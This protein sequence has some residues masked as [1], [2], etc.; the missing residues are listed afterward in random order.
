MKLNVTPRYQT[1]HPLVPDFSSFEF[2]RENS[3]EDPML[4]SDGET[5]VH[6]PQKR[7]MSKPEV[8][9]KRRRGNELQDSFLQ[10]VVQ[11]ARRN[12]VALKRPRDRQPPQRGDTQPVET[13]CD[14]G[15]SSLPQSPVVSDSTTSDDAAIP[16]RESLYQ[17]DILRNYHEFT[18][19]RRMKDA[20]FVIS[21][22]SDGEQ[23][24]FEGIFM[25][26]SDGWSPSSDVR[27][28]DMDSTMSDEQ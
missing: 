17:E 21:P 23:R 5:V 1:P 7:K 15:Y 13:Q 18:D 6:S 16:K 20:G 4:A 24:V 12:R 10:E 3:P 19:R 25:G 11:Y 27:S 9:A 26:E 28:Q 2:L 8:A 14:S 22:V